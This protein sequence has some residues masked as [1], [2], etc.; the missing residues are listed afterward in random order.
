MLTFSFIPRKGYLCLAHILE[1]TGEE[2]MGMP[3]AGE[4]MA[5][6]I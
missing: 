4:H 3:R 5:S 6:R 1:V 2:A